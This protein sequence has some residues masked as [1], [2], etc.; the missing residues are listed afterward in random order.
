M[1]CKCK[2]HTCAAQALTNECFVRRN[3]KGFRNTP[4]SWLMLFMCH[5]EHMNTCEQ[6]CMHACMFVYV[7]AKPRLWLAAEADER[8]S[9]RTRCAS[10]WQT[11]GASSSMLCGKPE[12]MK[13]IG[14][15]VYIV[16]M[17]GGFW[18]SL[19]SLNC[20]RVLGSG[21]LYFVLWVWGLRVW[22]VILGRIWLS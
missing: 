13:F 14:F 19:G 8:T 15:E 5:A 6:A 9:T 7:L 11:H 16:Y 20:I 2:S 22:I 10:E 12:L 1:P 17:V 3:R 21:V 18:V 4:L